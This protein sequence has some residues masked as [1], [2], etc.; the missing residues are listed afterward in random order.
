MLL[1]GDEHISLKE[2]TEVLETGLTEA[3][4][5]LIPPGMDE[6]VIGDTQRTRLKDIRA[7]FFIGVNEGIVPKAFGGGGI[8]SDMDREL[9]AGSGIELAPTKRQQAFIENFYIYLNMTKPKDRLYISFHMADEE[10]K[11]AVPSYLIGKL[12]TYFKK[13][14]IE[15]DDNAKTWKGCFRTEVQVS[16]KGFAVTGTVSI[17]PI[18]DMIN[19][20]IKGSLGCYAS[21][22]GVM[23]K[24]K[25][26]QDSSS[27]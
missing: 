14:G 20:L 24:M 2:F 10:G 17:K 13:L 18:M 6:I 8:L 21:C 22:T 25:K 11:S 1:L 15:Y 19:I 26:E 3:R 7:L 12:M 27:A 9:L 5:G 4:V 16:A 23:R